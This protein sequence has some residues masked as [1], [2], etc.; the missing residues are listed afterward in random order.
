[1]LRPLVSLGPLLAL[2]V[3]WYSLDWLQHD[4]LDILGY[5]EY[6]GAVIG[7]PAVVVS[8]VWSGTT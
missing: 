7:M 1:L 3:V 5:P 8:R 2:V 6:V 4:V